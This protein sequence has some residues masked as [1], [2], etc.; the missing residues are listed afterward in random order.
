LRAA[1]HG[2]RQ[3]KAHYKKLEAKPM[4]LLTG[5]PSLNETLVNLLRHYHR[6]LLASSPSKKKGPLM[7]VQ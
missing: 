2:L 7:T 5:K 1:T 3:E 4:L 6:A